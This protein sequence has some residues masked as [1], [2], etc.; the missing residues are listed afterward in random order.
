MTTYVAVLRG[1]NVGGKGKVPMVELRKV[2]EGMGFR[3]V[4]TYIQSGNVVF[5]T[6]VRDA[7][8]KLTAEILR[9]FGVKTFTVLRTVEE[10]RAIVAGN[11]FPGVEPTKLLVSF[12]QN[13]ADGAALAGIPI[14]PEEVRVMGKDMYIHFP[15][16]QGNSKFPM[17]K[18]ERALGTAGTGRNWNSVLKL[19]EMAEAL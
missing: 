18:V 4:K 3:D 10:M 6:G 9:V 8:E 16:G 5:R 11:P 19:L 13:E 12:L 7:G 14:G 17:A 2:C 15:I 1:I